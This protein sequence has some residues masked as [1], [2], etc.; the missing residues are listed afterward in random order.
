[1]TQGYRSKEHF[2]IKIC[3]LFSKDFHGEE[4]VFVNQTAA[5]FPSGVFFGGDACIL[6]MVLD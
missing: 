5:S 6:A 3:G 4:S 2:C 1:M